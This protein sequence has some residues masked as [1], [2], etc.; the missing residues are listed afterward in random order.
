[1]CV[2]EASPPRQPFDLSRADQR[3]LNAKGRY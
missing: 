2:D 1:M 3:F